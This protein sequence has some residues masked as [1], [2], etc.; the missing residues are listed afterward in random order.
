MSTCKSELLLRFRYTLNDSYTNL[1]DSDVHAI[2]VYLFDENGKYIDTFSEQ[3]DKLTNE[4]VMRIELPE[5]K[6]KVVVCGGDLTTYSVG[7]INNQT[8]MIDNPLRKGFTDINDFRIEL[9]NNIGED[10]FLYPSKIP[11]DLYASTAVSGVSVR[12]N[13]SVTDVELIKDTKK[14][15]V[16]IIG[17]ESFN[18]PLDVYITALNGRYKFDNSIDTNH[19]TF[20]YLPSPPLF[21]SNILEVNLK[22]MRLVLGQFPML[23]IKNSLTNKVLYNENM[24]EQIIST[25]QY[26]TQED[27]D[28]EDEFL[29]EISVVSSVIVSVSINGWVI[30]NV[31]PDIQ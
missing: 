27:F 5:G 20:K 16:R 9:K 23:V 18:E 7:E 24:I 17:S 14:I 25:Q 13:Q 30:N 22:M 15:K 8:N 29:F 28:R 3:G 10:E 2:S 11:D 12:N 6:Y 4:Y 1:F 19:K 21:N 31:N 26:L